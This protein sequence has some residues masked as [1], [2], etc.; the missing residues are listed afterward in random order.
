MTDRPRYVAALAPTCPHLS[1]LRI[2]GEWICVRC[3][4]VVSDDD[5]DASP[6]F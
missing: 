1:C 4:D 5:D 3:G 2:A 6:G